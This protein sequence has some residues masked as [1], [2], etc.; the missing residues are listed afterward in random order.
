MMAAS[1][2]CIGE[3]AVALADAAALRLDHG[4]DRA[5][6]H[7]CGDPFEAALGLR[8]IDDAVDGR[9]QPQEVS[10]SFS[11]VHRGVSHTR[12]RLLEMRRASCRYRRRG[13]GFEHVHRDH[14]HDL[15]ELVDRKPDRGQA[16]GQQVRIQ[17]FDFEPGPEAGHQ[18]IRQE[19]DMGKMAVLLGALGHVVMADGLGQRIG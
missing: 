16:R 4:A 8:E 5:D 13:G 3:G 12:A 9:E 11:Q 1:D 15:R 18:K 19:H 10:L 17:L 6:D 7:R 14:V 2:S